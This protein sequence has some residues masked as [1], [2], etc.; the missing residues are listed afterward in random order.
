MTTTMTMM[1]AM[2]IA[3]GLVPWMAAA[4]QAQARA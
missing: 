3:V 1:R 4:G 2:L